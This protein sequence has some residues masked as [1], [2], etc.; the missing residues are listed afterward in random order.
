MKK[1]QTEELGPEVLP[2]HTPLGWF[3]LS[4]NVNAE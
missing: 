4:E 1:L 2:F 3:S